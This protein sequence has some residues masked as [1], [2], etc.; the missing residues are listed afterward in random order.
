M[1]N[2]YLPQ[3]MD[4]SAPVFTVTVAARLAD[5][6]P[7]TLRGYD[8]QGL[9]IPSRTKGR[10]RRYSLRDIER[11]RHIQRLSQDEGIN[12]EGIRRILELENQLDAVSEQVGRLAQLLHRAQTTT[13]GRLFTAGSQGQ[14]YLGRTSPA[15]RPRALPSGH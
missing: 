3:R 8:R 7:Q 4:V 5:M 11:L 10:G 1:T 14:V 12:L 6:H 2:E 9:V 15:R 13:D